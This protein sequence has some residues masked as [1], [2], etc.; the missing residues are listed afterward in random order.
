M[1]VVN[2]FFLFFSAVLSWFTEPRYYRL[3]HF[4]HGREAR[5]LLHHPQQEPGHHQPRRMGFQSDRISGRTDGRRRGQRD[6]DS[7][8]SKLFQHGQEDVHSAR[9]LH[10][11]SNQHSDAGRGG[12]DERD[13]LHRHRLPRVL[14]SLQ[15]QGGERIIEHGAQRTNL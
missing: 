1:I 9:P 14:A 12:F 4:G 6:G 13:R 10:G 15:V 7:S 3:R 2:V 5:P 8:A 11:L